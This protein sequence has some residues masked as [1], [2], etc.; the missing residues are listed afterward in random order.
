MCCSIIVFPIS[1]HKA[2]PDIRCL[3]RRTVGSRDQEVDLR[4]RAADDVELEYECDDEELYVDDD[5]IVYVPE[6]YE[7]TARIVIT[8]DETEN[9]EAAEKTVTLRIR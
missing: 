1:G 7:G 4:V 9:Y 8:S 5:G 2:D 6:N 3:T